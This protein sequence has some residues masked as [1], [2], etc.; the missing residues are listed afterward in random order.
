V[1]IVGMKDLVTCREAAR[2]LGVSAPTLRK[3]IRRGDLAT[4]VNPLNDRTK[5][6]RVDDLETLRQP[7]PARPKET[8]ASAA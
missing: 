3:R 7:Q 6:V 2:R 8:A 5:L 1:N 4:F